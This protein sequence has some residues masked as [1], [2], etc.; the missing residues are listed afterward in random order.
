LGEMV[1]LLTKRTEAAVLVAVLA[2]TAPLFVYFQ[3]AIMP[4]IPSM[5]SAMIGLYFW[6]RYLIS[7]RK[8][9]Y[10]IA[11]SFLTLAALT[12]TTFLIPLLAIAGCELW[13]YLRN[14]SIPAFKIISF[15]AAAICIGGYYGYNSF[16]RAEYGSIFYRRSCHRKIFGKPELY[17]GTSSTDGDFTFSPNYIIWL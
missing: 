5:A 13:L 2:G 9:L 15:T 7:P 1:F 8:R 10:I 11:I 14:R 4:T 6:I 17:F 3:T 12:R 16:L